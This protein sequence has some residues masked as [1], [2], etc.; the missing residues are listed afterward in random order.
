MQKKFN[1]HLSANLQFLIVYH[2][3]SSSNLLK[4]KL[5]LVFC[6]VFHTNTPPLPYL[7]RISILDIR[8]EFLIIVSTM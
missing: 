1:N 3:V 8:F 6:F 4:N 2:A 7:R 5:C